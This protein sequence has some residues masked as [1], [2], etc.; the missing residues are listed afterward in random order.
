MMEADDLPDAEHAVF[1]IHGL[2]GTEY[3]MGSMHK[4]L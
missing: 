3:D 1:L 4:R 2:G